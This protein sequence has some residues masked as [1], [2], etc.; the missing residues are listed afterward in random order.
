MI[1]TQ[2]DKIVV[3]HRRLFP[4]DEVL[5]FVAAVDEYEGGMIKATGHSFLWD[6]SNGVMV[7]K[8]KARTKIMAISSGLLLVHLLPGSVVFDA[9]NF[10]VIDGSLNLSDGARFA[11]NM[12]EHT[13]DGMV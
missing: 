13:H 3:V 1:L 12:A 10:A 7:E 8:N 4:D 9:L 5:Y 6:Q 2:G 11:M